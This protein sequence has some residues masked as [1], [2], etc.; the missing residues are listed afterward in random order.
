MITNN[1]NRETFTY[2]HAR[3]L[4][5]YRLY[6]NI[7]NSNEKIYLTIDCKNSN[8]IAPGKYRTKA[9]D[10]QIQY[11]YFNKK[12]QFL[13]NFQLKRIKTNDSKIS[14]GIENLLDTTK[15]HEIRLL[16]INKELKDLTEK[17]VEIQNDKH[18]N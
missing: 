14:I 16:E 6:F 11:C 4:S 7:S 17:P 18:K 1:C 15:N 2:I 13:I 10:P 3:E 12:I 5:I 8:F 9:E